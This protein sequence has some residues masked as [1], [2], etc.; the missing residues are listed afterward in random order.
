M[1]EM[2]T[3]LKKKSILCLSVKG[4]WLY[5]PDKSSSRT[6]DAL[7]GRKTFLYS[8]QRT[9]NTQH[10]CTFHQKVFPSCL[11]L[12]WNFMLVSKSKLWLCTV[13]K[14]FAIKIK[15]FPNVKS[16]SCSLWQSWH[17]KVTSLAH[18]DLW[19]HRQL[20]FGVFCT[21]KVNINFRIIL[22]LCR[23]IQLKGFWISFFSHDAD[24]MEILLLFHW[25]E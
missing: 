22:E 18:R 14:V 15:I 23:N 7:E 12:I 24:I 9:R 11:C 8:H 2:L 13:P 6:A 17:A 3:R 19:S 10:L 20:K 21:Y 16:V 5:H 25:M 4:R 1:L